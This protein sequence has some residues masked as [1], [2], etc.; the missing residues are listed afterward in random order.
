MEQKEILKRI[1]YIDSE[2]TT[3]QKMLNSIETTKQI[4][5]PDVY[6]NLSAE[7]AIRAEKI[8]CNIRHLIYESTNTTKRE[9]M[10]KVSE[11]HGIDITYADGIFTMV[12][13]ALLP[14]KKQLK[15][16]EFLLDPIYFALDKYFTVTDIEK[17]KECVVCFTQ[18][19]SEETP[20]R[21]IRDYD[22][23]E[24]KQVL[25]AIAAYVMT[26]DSGAV[27]EI[28]NTTEYGKKDCTSVSVMSKDKFIEWIAK[29]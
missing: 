28:H 2:L 4:A 14:K 6:E 21:R 10:K 24:L 19:Y 29:R 1:A 23:I 18:I 9:Y 13:P 16:S 25:D 27:C 12:F 20:D 26:D 17:Y 5:F 11:A 7:A 3:L 8:T 15:N 22:N